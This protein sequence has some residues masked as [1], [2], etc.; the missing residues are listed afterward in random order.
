M[1]RLSAYTWF[2][3]LANLKPLSLALR[4]PQGRPNAGVYAVEQGVYERWC[5]RKTSL[6]FLF[7]S[8]YSTTLENDY[9][10]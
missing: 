9:Y 3:A 6:I 7:P 8:L 5:T 4:W 1:G 2:Y 10:K